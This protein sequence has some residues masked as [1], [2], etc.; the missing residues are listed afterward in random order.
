MTIGKSTLTAVIALLF[1]TLTLAQ[2]SSSAAIHR[3]QRTLPSSLT[4]LGLGFHRQTDTGLT[5]KA[6]PDPV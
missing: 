4:L 5:G 2:T 3:N 6:A 1:A